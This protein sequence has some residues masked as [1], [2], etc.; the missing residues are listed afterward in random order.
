MINMPNMLMIGAAER[1]VGKTELACEVIAGHRS[2]ADIVG[3][4]VSTVSEAH[5]E[6]TSIG[7]GRHAVDGPYEIIEEASPPPGKDTARLLAAGAK[8]VYRIK[9]RHEHL[10]EGFKELLRATGGGKL[11]VC[12]SNSLR[13]HVFPGI[14]LL[15]K[16]QFS[17][18]CKPSAAEVIKFADR[19]VLFDGHKQDI[20]PDEFKIIEGKW[21]W[22]IDANAVIMAGGNSTRM[23]TD[24]TLLQVNGEPLI[25]HLF[26]QL[27]GTFSQVLVST[28]E[29]REYDFL[30]HGR[31]V[32][33]MACGL[34]PLAGILSSL[35]NSEK[36]I[37]FIVACDIPEIPLYLVRQ[38]IAS[39]SGYDCVIPITPSGHLEPLF[40]IYR[41]S[42]IAPVREVLASGHRRV[43][44][45][46]A[47][48]RTN[49]FKLDDS[50]ALK[51]LNT[52]DEYRDY[53][54]EQRHDQI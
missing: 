45:I 17:G 2:A 36:D 43:R 6:P 41:K 33:D 12:E 47:R 40:G 14:F 24:K 20:H 50:T 49:Y 25:K 4:K 18:T 15:V 29:N 22:P 35:E 46:F 26:R 19:L 9:A 54:L 52:L 39:S 48:V 51:N 13:L 30:D 11:I 7:R 38:M 3:I 16:R 53:L 23:G 21:I 37:N 10:R 34:G 8:R 28:G 31:V 44:D 42:M 32:Y 5:G 1:N 27:H